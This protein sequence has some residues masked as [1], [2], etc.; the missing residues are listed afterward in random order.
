MR[1]T[2]EDE[3]PGWIRVRLTGAIL[4]RDVDPLGHVLHECPVVIKT[5]IYSRIGRIA[6]SYD[7]H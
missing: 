6:I 1:Y 5:H 7:R 2:I 3:V 4:P